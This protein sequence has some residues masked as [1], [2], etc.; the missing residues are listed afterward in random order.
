MSLSE[1]E[2]LHIRPR[3]SFVIPYPAEE[4]IRRIQ[5]K[6]DEPHAPCV[7]KISMDHVFLD[8]PQVDQH[9]WSPQM[10]FYLE[11]DETDP[12]KTQIRGLFG[13][14]PSVWTLFLFF[15]LAVGLVGMVFSMYGFSKWSLGT[16]SYAIYGLPV[17]LVVMSTAYFMGK[18]GEKLGEDQILILK[19]FFK[20][21]LKG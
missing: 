20:A 19:Q 16:F 17:A 4:I 3:F 18:S 10:S 11:P 15:Y 7:G 9:F 12:N 6:L 13:P 1:V 5:L 14:K 21:A 2:I 8:I